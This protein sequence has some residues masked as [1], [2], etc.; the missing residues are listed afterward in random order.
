M[1]FQNSR[2]GLC[3][4][5]CRPMSSMWQW[6]TSQRGRGSQQGS[7]RPSSAPAPWSGSKCQC[8][9]QPAG[10]RTEQK[11][12]VMMGGFEGLGYNAT[13]VTDSQR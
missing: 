8:L 7:W 1:R 2:H 6:Q 13:I 4:T 9:E 3:E 11:E 10:Y 12:A 5:H